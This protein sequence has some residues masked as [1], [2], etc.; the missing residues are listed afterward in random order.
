MKRRELIKSITVMLFGA[1]FPLVAF[2]KR[3]FKVFPDYQ[4]VNG[5]VIP[6][7]KLRSRQQ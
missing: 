6:I 1:S 4:V 5:W 2:G 7:E 3:C